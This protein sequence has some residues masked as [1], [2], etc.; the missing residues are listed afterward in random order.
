MSDLSHPLPTFGA[1]SPSRVKDGLAAAIVVI[2][3]LS[4]LPAG[5]VLP[6]SW[7]VLALATGLLGLLAALLIPADR[8]PR[9]TAIALLLAAGLVPCAFAMLHATMA[10]LP[11]ATQSLHL[12]DRELTLRAGSLSPDATLAGAVRGAA[13]VMFLWLV[14]CTAS[15]PVR[16]RRM[17]LAIFAGVAMQGVWALLRLGPLQDSFAPGAYPGAAVGTFVGRNALA[18]HLG[19]GLVLGLA[20]LPGRAGWSGL[21]G[22]ALCLGLLV[23]GTALVATQSRMGITATG[24]AALVV[25]VRRRPG[26]RM[27]TA[28]AGATLA[29]LALGGGGVIERMVWLAPEAQ[30]RLDLCAQVWPMIA[31]R[32][33]SGWG[34]DTFPLAFEIFHRPPV[35]SELVWDRAHSTYLTLWAELGLV[36]GSL[37]ILAGFLVAALLIRRPRV[38]VTDTAALAA[39]VLAGVHSLTD[40][41]LEIPANLFLLLALVGLGLARSGGP[42]NVPT[43]RMT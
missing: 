40:F 21:R 34:L 31:A 15:D 24:I 42:R 13:A 35:P 18:T 41:S 37:P 26:W 11:I 16:A 28:L 10:Y 25:V 36:A 22:P 8:K 39:L 12:P 30:T 5:S 23:I 1:L 19:M 20:L 6:Q 29:L 33:L 38:R 14:L 2:V 3:P 4:A 32:P 43:E 9:G 7:A 27:M 17:A